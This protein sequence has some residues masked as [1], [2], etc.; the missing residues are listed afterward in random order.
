MNIAIDV[1]GILGSMGRNRGIGYYTFIKFIR[2]Y[3][4]KRYITV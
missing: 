3:F 1:M 4:F 2:G